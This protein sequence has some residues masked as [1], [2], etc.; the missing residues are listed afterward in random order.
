M[1]IVG[2]RILSSSVAAAW[3]IVVAASAQAASRSEAEAIATRTGEIIGGA[4][5]CGI[6]EGE[7]VALGAKVIRWARDSARSAAE[8]K[9]AQEAHEAAVQRS[10]DRVGWRGASACDATVRTFR[11]LQRK[12]Q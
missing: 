4:S 6:P 10:A 1:Q 8:L 12:M 2:R 5:A 9:R 7:L 11:E 3:L